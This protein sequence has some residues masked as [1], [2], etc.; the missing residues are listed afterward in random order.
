MFVSSDAQFVQ[1]GKI[2]RDSDDTRV[3][4]V[5]T[6]QRAKKRAFPG[7]I[8]PQQAYELALR[9]IERDVA[10]RRERI[11]LPGFEKNAPTRPGIQEQKSLGHIAASDEGPA[12]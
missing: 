9:H 2:T 5:D 11:P 10:E 8:A 4:R 7:A 1:C 6:A 3:G 12:G